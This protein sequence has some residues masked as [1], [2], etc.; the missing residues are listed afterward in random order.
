MRQS[1]Q[2]QITTCPL[3]LHH[4]VPKG[5]STQ[6]SFPV[7]R[8]FSQPEVSPPPAPKSTDGTH[9]RIV[10][11]KALPFSWKPHKVCQRSSDRDCLNKWSHPLAGTGPGTSCWSR[12]YAKPR[13]R[14]RVSA[15]LAKTRARRTV[16]YL[17]WT[18]DWGH[19]TALLRLGT[20]GQ[21]SNGSPT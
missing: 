14:R 16:W 13:R 15:T 4:L 6:H 7:T 19:C 11:H 17:H 9:Q 3:L 8:L 20:L 10:K 21:S 1:D 5:I 12:S 18:I 2:H